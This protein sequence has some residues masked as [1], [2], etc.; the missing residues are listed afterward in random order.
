[1]DLSGASVLVVGGTGGIGRAVAEAVAA[2]GGRLH[3]L[4]RSAS[5]LEA[6]ARGTGGRA[7]S[8]DL[9]DDAEVWAALDALS[10]TLGGPPDAVVNTAGTF[11]LASLAST[12]V[13]AFDRSLAVNL[14]GPFLVIR[15]V[16]P[17]MLERKHGRIVNVGSVAG[18]K[19][20]PENGAY[21]AAKFGLRGLHEVLVEELRGTGV[22]ATL[23]EPAATDTA[24]WDE[25][26]PDERADL[27]TRADMLRPHQVAEVVLFALTRPPGVNLPLIQIER[28]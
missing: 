4:S 8:V 17:G 1:M 24:A 5:S 18:R 20:F 27:P 22:Q 12:S 16:L 15:A 28:G 21:S 26:G 10:D 19:A 6:L 7:W 3:L 13:E 2:L 23:V 11:E 25:I 14:R 9:T